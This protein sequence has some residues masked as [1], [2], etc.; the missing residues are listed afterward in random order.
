[1]LKQIKDICNKFFDVKHQANTVVHAL[2]PL[3]WHD[4]R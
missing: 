2:V 4:L 1:M 3:L